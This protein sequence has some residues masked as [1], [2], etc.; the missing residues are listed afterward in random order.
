MPIIGEMNLLPADEEHL[1][2]VRQ[3]DLAGVVL[4]IG[5]RQKRADR[6]EDRGRGEH[7]LAV[8]VQRQIGLQSQDREPDDERHER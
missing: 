2:E 4:Q 8:R 6:V 1:A 5:V 7:P 3:V